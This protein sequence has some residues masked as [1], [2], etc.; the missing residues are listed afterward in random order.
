MADCENRFL[1][2]EPR[3]EIRMTRPNVSAVWKDSSL[4]LLNG[5]RGR[6]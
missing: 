2:S 6:R 1:H 3:F 5:Y 4:F